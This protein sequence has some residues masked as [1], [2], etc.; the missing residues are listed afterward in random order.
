MEKGIQ[1]REVIPLSSRN[2]DGA[3]AAL[4]KPTWKRRLSV[5]SD[6]REQLINLIHEVQVFRHKEGLTMH[7]RHFSGSTWLLRFLRQLYV[8]HPISYYPNRHR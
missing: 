6:Q 2:S 5:I 7:F 1:R 8:R 3:L 4:A